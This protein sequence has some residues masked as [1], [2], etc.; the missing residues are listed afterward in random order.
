[1]MYN[2]VLGRQGGPEVKVPAIKS[3][4]LSSIPRTDMVARELTHNTHNRDIF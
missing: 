1:M 4:D 3:N 2:K